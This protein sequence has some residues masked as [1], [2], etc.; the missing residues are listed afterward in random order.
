VSVFG[1]VKT[2][3]CIFAPPPPSLPS[4]PSI[5]SAWPLS[6]LRLRGSPVSIP[7]KAYNFF[8]ARAK[9][10][11]FFFISTRRNTRIP[12]TLVPEQ[13]TA[14]CRMSRERDSDSG[15]EGRWHLVRNH[16]TKA[17][18]Y[19]SLRRN[20]AAC[21]VVFLEFSLDL[22]SVCFCHALGTAPILVCICIR[23]TYFVFP[24]NSYF[25]RKLY[26]KLYNTLNVAN[27]FR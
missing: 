1:A 19:K 9:H 5:W 8:S 3:A 2:S 13:W 15:E 20:V 14:F 24:T 12:A 22:W 26:N 16:R 10:F 27:I 11:F 4:S 23:S 21:R 6:V 17:V 7:K 25:L 18:L